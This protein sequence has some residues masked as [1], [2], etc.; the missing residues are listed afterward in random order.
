MGFL[1]SNREPKKPLE[2]IHDKRKKPKKSKKGQLTLRP[3][4]SSTL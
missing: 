3:M 2:V 1:E 4:G